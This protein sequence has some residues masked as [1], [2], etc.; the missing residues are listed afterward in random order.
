MYIT[1]RL[2]PIKQFWELNTSSVQFPRFITQKG[3][4]TKLNC[5]K[6]TPANR[7]I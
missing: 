6:R 2:T 5:K 4:I 3:H 7:I 1:F